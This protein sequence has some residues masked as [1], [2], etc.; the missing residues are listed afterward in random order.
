[1][2]TRRHQAGTDRGFI[3]GAVCVI[4]FRVCAVSKKLVIRKIRAY[5]KKTKKLSVYLKQDSKG[6]QEIHRGAQ[7]AQ[8]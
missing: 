7:A 2:R 4:N 6:D 1:M 3:S 8:R 5:L